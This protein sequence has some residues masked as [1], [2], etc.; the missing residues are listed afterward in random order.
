MNGGFWGPRLETN[1]A[2]T[3]PANWRKCEE[4]GR[5]ENFE[6]AAKLKPGRHK[7]IFFDDSDVYKVCEGAAYT[8]ALQPDPALDQYLEDLV[9]LF[10]K[11]QEPDGYLYTARHHRPGTSGQLRQGPLGEPERRP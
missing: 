1:R 3:L 9:A 10:A 8:L 2:S 4:T 11:A 7:G 5:I 6:K